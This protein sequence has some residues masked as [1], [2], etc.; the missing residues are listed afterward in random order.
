MFII[1]LYRSSSARPRAPRGSAGAASS[2]CKR[3]IYIYIYIYVYIYIYIHTHMYTYT[4]SGVQQI[5]SKVP[6]R[7]LEPPSPVES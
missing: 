1:I 2:S 7:F 3:N 4:Y 6:L 5:L